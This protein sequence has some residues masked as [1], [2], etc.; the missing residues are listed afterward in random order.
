MPTRQGLVALGAGIVAI[1][2]GRV[3]AILELFVIG[4]AM[5]VAVAFGIAFVAMRAPRLT[6]DRWAHPAMLSAG[7]SGAVDIDLVHTGTLR[8]TRFLLEESIRRPGDAIQVAPLGVE[9]LRPDARVR[10][11]YELPT[12]RRGRIELGPLVAV[13]TDPLGVARTTRPVAGTSQVV[14][15]PRAY[16]LP[17]PVLG[18]GPLGQQ[19]LAQA[20]RLGFGEFHS[21]REYVDG[22]EPRSIHWRA[23]ARSDDL[24]V[25]QHTLEGLKRAIVVLDPDPSSYAD[26][27]SF[28]R[29]VTAAASLVTSAFHHELATRFVTG[30]GIDL[31]GPDVAA[32]TL[33]VLSSIEPTTGALPVLDRD[34]GEGIGL[35][36]LVTGS[37]GSAGWSAVASIV[38][39]TITVVPVTTD[40][41]P[42]SKLGAAART[43][44]EFVRSWQALAGSHRTRTRPTQ[45]SA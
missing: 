13:V 26:R 35:A 37:P 41:A 14:V 1:V 34:P 28:E 22:D 3:F 2:V 20:R 7:E 16:Q 9:P 11:G 18:S 27:A 15:A 43:D 39:P 10:T 12:S 4:T 19:L 23:S 32:G 36:I 31:R 38:D 29:A 33:D 8:S 40:V 45:R 5:I 42:R 44:D 21:L 25:K 24:L 30:R 6:A 17:M